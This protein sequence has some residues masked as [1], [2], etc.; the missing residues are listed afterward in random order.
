MFFC[1][2]TSALF[3]PLILGQNTATTNYASGYLGARL[4]DHHHDAKGA[5]HLLSDDRE[6]YMIIPCSAQRKL[7]T[8]QLSREIELHLV[9]I[10]NLEY[11]SSTVKD[12]SILG[13]R[14]Y[15]CLPPNCL[16]RVLGNFQANQTRT[17]QHFFI[18]RQD[19]IRFIR[20]LW[21]TSYGREQSCTMTS[22]HA[23]GVDALESFVVDEEDHSPPAVHQ[24][25]IRKII[26]AP[27]PEQEVAQSLKDSVSLHQEKTEKN[28]LLIARHLNIS[29]RGICRFSDREVEEYFQFGAG[30]TSPAQFRQYI[31]SKTGLP[32]IG[33][34]L[35]TLQGDISK[36]IHNSEEQRMHIEIIDMQ[37]HHVEE[38]LVNVS[39]DAEEWRRLSKAERQMI[40]ARCQ[41]E[42]DELRS[43]VSAGQF[44][45]VLC[46]IIANIV[47]L[48]A[49]GCAI[50]S[51]HAM[52]QHTLGL[53]RASSF[54]N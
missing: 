35:K 43:S 11:F 23:Y 13:S 1:I 52:G 39:V 21:V 15:P 2:A 49:L 25:N 19:P 7:F 32:S 31:P 10:L 6:K 3:V 12:F 5:Q 9:S 41:L 28:S 51:Q 45:I 54:S 37:L 46:V 4:V 48:I 8:V 47:A 33:R 16:W 30:A 36:L 14:T 29:V 18:E 27:Q 44:N 17:L 42:L 22:F 40:H 24:Y 34:I 20:F 38:K 53:R 50:S 26:R